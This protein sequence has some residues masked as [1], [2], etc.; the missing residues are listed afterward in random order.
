M[1]EKKVAVRIIPTPATQDIAEKHLLRLSR[2]TKLPLEIVRE[3]LSKG[4]GITIVTPDHPRVADLANMI[5]ALG[6]SVTTGVVAEKP[7]TPPSRPV[8]RI[9][10]VSKTSPAKSATYEWKVGDVIDNLYEVMDIKQGGMGSVYIV[11]H[12]RWNSMIAVKSLLDRLKESEEDQALFLKE[13]ETWIDIGFHPNIASCY[14]VRN[15]QGSPRIFIEY[16][17]GG[18]LSQWTY[19][20]RQAGWDLILD[21]MAQVGDGLEHAHAKGLVHRDIKPANCMLTKDLVV[22]VTDFGLTKR[23]VTD[24]AEEGPPDVSTTGLT[25][26]RI[27]KDREDVTAAGMGTPGFMAPEMWIP[28]AEVGPPADI[29]AFGIMFFEIC[30]GRKPFV[31]MRGERRDKL[32]RAHLKKRPPRPTSLRKDMPQQVEDIILRCLRKRPSDRYPSF[33]EVRREVEA[34]YQEIFKRTFPR[35]K[36]DE[37]RLLADALNNRAVSLVDLHHLEEAREALKSALQS[38]PHHPEAVYNL[39]VLEWMRTGNPDHELVVKMEE[40]VKAP[41]YRGRGAHLLGKALLTLGDAQQAVKACETALT[42]EDA[43]EDWLKTCGIALIGAGKDAD[44]TGRLLSYL[45]A[46]PDDDDARGWLIGAFARA[47]KEQDALSAISSLPDGSALAGMGPKEISKRFQFS[48]RSERFVLEG[49]RG[50]VMCVGHCPKTRNFVS[51]ARDRTLKIWDHR[52]GEEIRN[53]TVVGQPPAFLSVSPDERLVAITGAKAGDPVNVLDLQSGRFAGNLLAPD[54]ITVAGFTPDSKYVIIV[55]EKGVVRLWDTEGFKAATTFKIPAHTAADLVFDRKS[56]PYVVLAGR[57]RT[58]KRIR[59]EDAETLTYEKCHTEPITEL[60]A[61]P[62][63]NRVLTCGRDRQSVVWDARTGK[64]VAAFAPGQE[65]LSQIA[66][67]P[68]LHLAAVYSPS[69]GI[70]LWDTTSG[71]VVRT[72]E[73]GNAEIQCLAFSPDGER[74]MAGGREMNV[75]VWDVRGRSITPELALTK[76]RPVSKQ[77]QSDREFKDILDKAKKAVKQ[78]SYAK[79]YSLVRKAQTLP[80]YERSDLALEM[81]LRMKD[82]GTRVG[83]RGGWNRKTIETSGSVMDVAFSPSA[84]NFLTAQAD[85][86]VRMW[87]TKTGDCLKVLKGHTNL[88]SSLAFSFNGREAVTGGDDRTVRVWELNTGKNVSVFKGHTDS[89]SSVAYSRNGETVLSGSWDGTVKLWSLGDG[90]LVRTHKGHEDKVGAVGMMDNADL[91]LAG[92]FDGVVRMWEISSGKDVRRVKG[93]KEKV[94]SLAVSIGD[95]MFASASLDGL[96]RIWDVHTGKTLRVLEV[97]EAGVRT[98]AFSQDHKFVISGGND[99][100]LRI[101]SVDSGEC[102][103]EFQGHSKEITAADSSSN[104]RFVISSSVDGSVMIWEVD[105]EWEFKDEKAAWDPWAQQ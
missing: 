100:V 56:R 1:A 64:K 55:E 85:H 31:V 21:L 72:F 62:D 36:P 92:G 5:K 12:L 46:F 83:L 17:D 27:V 70:K 18:S 15:I 43:G 13:A 25:T 52:T 74:L 54:G 9:P 94:T 30:C 22:K 79:V 33:A 50:W 59:L 37:V 98:V 80:G 34:A 71:M 101:W 40:V 93:H 76:V 66:L 16:V 97:D 75:R 23:R 73:P 53:Y 102:L 19:R 29:Y 91:I 68:Q 86:T 87:S 42:A 6:F 103:R 28:N 47:G 51:G 88:V 10:P 2:I 41:E 26:S 77:M 14:Y 4:K 84:I 90:S 69:L 38:D 104:G 81:I 99:S 82:H 95:D 58:V 35:P 39:G 45:D 105:W 20:R 65:L 60:K 8:Q 89:V 78:G 57:D 24:D 44:A 61:R 63:G 11:R 7:H 67:N 49:H 3:R 48:G 32:A 96:V